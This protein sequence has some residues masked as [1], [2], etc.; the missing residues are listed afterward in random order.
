MRSSKSVGIMELERSRDLGKFIGSADPARGRSHDD[1]AMEHSRLSFSPVASA[2]TSNRRA[3]GGSAPP[4]AMVPVNAIWSMLHLRRAELARERCEV[5]C[6]RIGWGET[7]CRGHDLDCTA[8]KIGE[9]SDSE[10]VPL[11]EPPMQ[12]RHGLQLIGGVA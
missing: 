1:L 2:H 12:I 7:T 11:S 4:S 10:G 5:G 8:P 3:N 6:G 9:V